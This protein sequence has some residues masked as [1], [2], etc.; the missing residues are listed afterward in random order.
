MKIIDVLKII[1]SEGMGFNIGSCLVEVFRYNVTK[2][3]EHLD[4]A[5][6]FLRREIAIK[7]ANIKKTVEAFEGGVLKP[8]TTTG[9]VTWTI[10]QN[11]NPECLIK[12]D[13]VKDNKTRIK[14][15]LKLFTEPEILY[16]ECD[17]GNHYI[18]FKEGD[19][20]GLSKIVRFFRGM[21]KDGC[22]LFKE[23]NLGYTLVEDGVV[24]IR[25]FESIYWFDL[26]CY[27][28]QKKRGDRFS[29]VR[30][31]FVIDECKNFEWV[32]ND[33]KIIEK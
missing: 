9:D 7:D 15:S 22:F 23:E 31:G 32:D 3:K 6:E 30:D 1:D 29:I 18:H 4:G 28:F 13:I 12:E 16:I 27:A 33:F 20:K 10:Q 26:G 17:N 19:N 11:P 21:N 5:I 25:D 2:K 8:F 14:R 24:I